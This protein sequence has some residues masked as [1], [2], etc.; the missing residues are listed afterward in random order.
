KFIPKGVVVGQTVELRPDQVEC[1]FFFFL[2]SSRSSRSLSFLSST[3]LFR[4][5]LILSI[6]K[7]LEIS[8]KELIFILKPSKSGFTLGLSSFFDFFDMI[9]SFSA[10][11]LRCLTQKLSA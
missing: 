1:Y 5:S 10:K 6:E 4:N 11:L 7:E 2:T 3:F 8:P 9:F